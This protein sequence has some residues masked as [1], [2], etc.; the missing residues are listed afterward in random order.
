M[1]NDSSFQVGH[2]R[3]KVCML[4]EVQRGVKCLLINVCGWRP[5]SEGAQAAGRSAPTLQ[6]GGGPG[7]NVLGGITEPS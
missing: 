1:V 5:E 7:R 2:M 3:I 6:L 4:S